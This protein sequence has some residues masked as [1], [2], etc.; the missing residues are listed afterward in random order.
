MNNLMSGFQA[1]QAI[2]QGLRGAFVEKPAIQQAMNQVQQGAD[3]MQVYQALASSDVNAANQFL[4]QIQGMQ[5][6]QVNAARLSGFEQQQQDRSSR[7]QTISEFAGDDPVMQLFISDPQ[8]AGALTRYISEKDSRSR[9]NAGVPLIGALSVTNPEAKRK[10]LIEASQKLGEFSPEIGGAIKDIVELPDEQLDMAIAPVV[11]VLGRMNF[12]PKDPLSSEGST[13]NIQNFEYYARLREQDPEAAERFA[14]SAN[15]NPDERLRRSIEEAQ[16]KEQV[17]GQSKRID[18]M[19]ATGQ[20]QVA[21]IGG[22][23]RAIDLLDKVSTGGYAAMQ[24]SVT[25]FFGVT[26]ADEAEFAYLT[27]KTVLGQLKDTFGAQFT[28]EEAKRLERLEA[29]IGRS[30]E[31]NMAILNRARESAVKA[32]LR[33]YRAA[34]RQGD[35][36]TAQ[37][38]QQA[39]NSAGYD[40]EGNKINTDGGARNFENEYGVN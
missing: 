39:L 8:T 27:G 33:G 6:S 7:Q 26:P 24:K 17:K 12:I 23:N 30:V 22:M 20:R 28:N 9:A 31:A 16:G 38:I 10:L 2:G 36:F 5:Q 29:G 4:S 14:Q 35:E 11:N 21:V 3:P 34:V 18:E 1:G 37:E 15:L 40:V 19:V 32:A 13:A 25:D